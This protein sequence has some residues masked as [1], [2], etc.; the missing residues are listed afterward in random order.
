VLYLRKVMQRYAREINLYFVIIMAPKLIAIL[1]L[2]AIPHPVFLPIQGG[3]IQFSK[4][5]VLIL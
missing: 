3:S 5:Q 2:Q 1:P 4:I